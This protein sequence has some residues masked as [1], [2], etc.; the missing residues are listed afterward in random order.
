MMKFNRK[1]NLK[2]CQSLVIFDL[3]LFHL[4]S[5][6][7]TALDSNKL[8]DSTTCSSCIRLTI[9]SQKDSIQLQKAKIRIKELE[10]EV[11]DLKLKI[12]YMQ[13]PTREATIAAVKPS[14]IE[15]IMERHE[16]KTITIVNVQGN[17]KVIMP[18]TSAN[19]HE[20]TVDLTEKCN[21]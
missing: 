9:Q 14:S 11:V 2:K 8:D 7:T 15:N 19:N 10:R 16:N 5:F 1:N 17:S 6:R 4:V 21:E 18:M 12:Q 13:R 3:N 20:K